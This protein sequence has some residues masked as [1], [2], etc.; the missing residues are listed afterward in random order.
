MIAVA[1]SM[2]PTRRQACRFWY[3]SMGSPPMPNRKGVVGGSLASRRMSGVAGSQGSSRAMRGDCALRE[4]QGCTRPSKA[5]AGVC[6]CWTSACVARER[7]SCRG[8][9]AP[10]R[11]RRASG[12]VVVVVVVAGPTLAAHRICAGQ[13]QGSVNCSASCVG[14]RKAS[15]R[16]FRRAARASMLLQVEGECINDS[17][18]T[19]K[20]EKN[21]RLGRQGRNGPEESAGTMGCSGRGSWWSWRAHGNGKTPSTCN[22][23]ISLDRASGAPRARSST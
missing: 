20:W 4:L 2:R 18:A 8:D 14:D 11:G 17:T 5:T 13:S 19:N 23:R 3:S 10:C 22:I 15:L 1:R 21:A 9:S 16:S 12:V 6:A 7:V